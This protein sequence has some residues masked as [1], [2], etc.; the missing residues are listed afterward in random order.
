MHTHFTASFGGGGIEAFMGC[1]GSGQSG[2][3][4]QVFG[5][6]G[7]PAFRQP[8]IMSIVVEARLESRG[9]LLRGC[10]INTAC[11][12][13]KLHDLSPTDSKPAKADCHTQ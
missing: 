7:P 9:Y 3:K 11:V 10:P 6:Q 2:I 1:R 13:V 4:Q 12:G 5:H 8:S